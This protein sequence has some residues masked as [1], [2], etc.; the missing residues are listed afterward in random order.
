[1]VD[2]S[3]KGNRGDQPNNGATDVDDIDN[4][5]ILMT[6]LKFN[7]ESDERLDFKVKHWKGIAE[8]IG[9]SEAAAK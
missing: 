7:L 6:I 5:M 3:N 9:I 2:K 1:M 4:E 8:E